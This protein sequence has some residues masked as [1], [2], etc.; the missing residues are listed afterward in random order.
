MNTTEPTWPVPGWRRAPG[1]PDYVVHR[2]TLEVWSTGRRVPCKGGATRWAPAKRINPTTDGRVPLSQSGKTTLVH[3]VRYLHP[4]TFPEKIRPQVMCRGGHPL[5]DPIRPRIF[6][7]FAEPNVAEWGT[8][9]RVCR[10]CHPPEQ[11]PAHYS[12]SH[13]TAQPPRYSDLPATP[14]PCADNTVDEDGQPLIHRIFLFADNYLAYELTRAILD[15]RGVISEKLNI[16]NR[17]I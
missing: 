7:R 5:T 16:R 6:G 2:D 14:V 13:G 3:V 15:R 12:L 11:H 1:W 4:L 10:Y 17:S 8:G 9:N